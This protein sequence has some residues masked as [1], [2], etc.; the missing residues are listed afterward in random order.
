[1]PNWKEEIGRIKEE[2]GRK[3]DDAQHRLD[4]EEKTRTQELKDKEK[5]FP[6]GIM[7][8]YENIILPGFEILD[9]FHIKEA[10][11]EIRDQIWKVG[12]II[13]RPNNF[14]EFE[15]RSGY[16]ALY[17][18]NSTYGFNRYVKI[19]Y[20]EAYDQNEKLPILKSKSESGKIDYERNRSKIAKYVLIGPETLR[21]VPEGS[22]PNDGSGDRSYWNERLEIYRPTLEI[23]VNNGNYLY[24][25]ATSSSTRECPEVWNIN[26]KQ[27]SREEIQ[28]D[29]R[30][31]LIIDSYTRPDYSK[32]DS[33]ILNHPKLYK[34]YLELHHTY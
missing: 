3:K 23:S 6:L 22:S 21:Y 11:I 33:E 9:S 32:M 15:L 30:L 10:L 7:R 17:C 19:D 18:D 1:M 34:R 20:E 28:E 27:K 12:E 2:M 24:I 31:C 8:D 29:I 26:I 16:S 25:V 13:K 5:E 4:L 14:E